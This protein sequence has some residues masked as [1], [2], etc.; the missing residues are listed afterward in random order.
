[1]NSVEAIIDRS[2]SKI[3]T[4][5]VLLLKPGIILSVTFTGFAGMV[6]ANRGIPSADIIVFGILSLFLS[7]SGSAILNNI[8]DKQIDIMMK[9]LNRRVEALRV[10]GEKEA[11]FISVFF[12]AISL[13][14]SSLFLNYVNTILIIAAILSY[15]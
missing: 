3:L 7:A 6:L 10:V 15:T 11:V 1:E 13:F 9:R 2:P 5:I 8:F 4:S 12:I 14:I